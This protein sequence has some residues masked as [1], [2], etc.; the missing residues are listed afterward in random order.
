MCTSRHPYVHLGTAAVNQTV[1]NFP[2]KGRAF[3]IALHSK[4]EK[5]TVKIS[6]RN[7]KISKIV[8][9]ILDARKALTFHYKFQIQTTVQHS[10]IAIMLLNN[11]ADFFR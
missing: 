9:S 5:P 11:R 8:C 7:Y 6:N 10:S 1:Y 2:V 3:A 4:S